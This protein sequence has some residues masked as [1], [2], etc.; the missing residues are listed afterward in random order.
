MARPTPHLAATHTHLLDTKESTN[1]ML[2]IISRIDILFMYI[3][4]N[5]PRITHC[6]LKETKFLIQL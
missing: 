5:I 1:K 6:E 3:M 2:N 4:P